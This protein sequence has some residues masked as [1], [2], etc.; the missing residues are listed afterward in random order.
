VFA[1]GLL[2]DS[3]SGRKFLADCGAVY[4]IL[5]FSSSELPCGPALVTA[6]K[7]PVPCWGRRSC[8][9]RFGG[10][11]FEWSFLLAQVSFPIIG[12]DFL[13][14]FDLLVDLNRMQLVSGRHGWAVPMV[15]PPPGSTFAAPL[16]VA[17]VADDIGVIVDH[18]EDATCGRSTGEKGTGV[19]AAGRKPATQAASRFQKVMEEFPTV[20]NPSKV[21]PDVK[22]HVSHR[23][24]TTGHASASRYR[25]L[26]PAKLKAAKEEF[27]ELEKQG[28][29]RRSSSH[30]ASPLH[31]VRKAD[32]TWRPCGDFRLLNDAFPFLFR[33][34]ICILQCYITKKKVIVKR[35]IQRK[36]S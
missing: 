13:R 32:G 9:V 8:K 27:T 17:P 19:R 28:I 31:M 5:P 23:I 1:A 29:I 20:L 36:K 30:W 21:L 33:L 14:A 26:D 2:T 6:S 25:R 11:N 34:F 4:S 24:E 18:K 22:H 35:E 10:R 15:A 7:T 16:G 12:A 3:R